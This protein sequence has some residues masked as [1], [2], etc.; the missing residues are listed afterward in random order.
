M[1]QDHT[2]DQRP[3]LPSIFTIVEKAQELRWTLQI[4]TI[5]LFADLM[6]TLR[7][8]AGITHWSM[9]TDQ[10][11]A[12]SG[13]LLTAVLAFCVL[14]SIVF[15]LADYV[16]HQLLVVVV[17]SL[18]WPRWMYRQQ[19]RSRPR[20]MVTSNELR[21]HAVDT[22]NDAFLERCDAHRQMWFAANTERWAMGR[23]VFSALV[24]AF[25]DYFA[26]VFGIGGV[27]VLQNFA[28]TL[29]QSGEF[30]LAAGAMLGCMSLISLWF[31][32]TDD[33]WI[34]YPPLYEKIVHEEMQARMVARPYY[35]KPIHGQEE[36]ND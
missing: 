25:I 19:D 15:P 18:P 20:D 8:G 12:N 14:M 22:C 24:L 23:V 32:E 9:R 35:A 29:G 2:S 10:L 17:Y 1:T 3:S 5:V 28:L 6:L 16:C 26:R 4:S 34:N 13:V 33:Q 11:L 21:D 7:T 36:H 30:I 31:P 27:T